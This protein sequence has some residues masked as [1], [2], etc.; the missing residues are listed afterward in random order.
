MKTNIFED[1]IVPECFNASVSV[2]I[3][4]PRAAPAE[5]GRKIKKN[6]KRER[7]R[8]KERERKRERKRERER[9]RKRQRNLL[10]ESVSSELFF[11]A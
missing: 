11:S 2:N 8:E 3:P 7:K 9:E 10:H 1:F 4:F 6:G 5:R